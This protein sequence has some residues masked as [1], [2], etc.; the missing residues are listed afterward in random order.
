MKK[1]ELLK[2]K[3]KISQLSNEEKKLR[4]NYLRDITLGKIYG[5]MTGYSSIDMP[6]LQYYN[7]SKYYEI[8]K[9]ET[10]PQALLRQNKDNL[11]GNALEFFFSNIKNFLKKEM[12]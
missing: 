12:N 10:V 8:V 4:D 3:E 2:L 1:E 6:S 11:E 9:Q 5:P 7:M